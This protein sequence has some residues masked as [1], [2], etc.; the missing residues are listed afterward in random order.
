[1]DERAGP[2]LILASILIVI[3]G[4]FRAWCRKSPVLR[5]GGIGAVTAI[6]GLVALF[7]SWWGL[8]MTIGIWALDGS[9]AGP[10]TSGEVLFAV[11]AEILVFFFPLGAW[12]LCVRF[13]GVL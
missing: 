4:Y 6:L 8:G 13:E 11:V 2:I 7:A 1:M 3:V 5:K 12:Y 9:G 10:H